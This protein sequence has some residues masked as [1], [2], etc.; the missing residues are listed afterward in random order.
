MEVVEIPLLLTVV[1]AEALSRASHRR[2]VTAGQMVRKA[3]EEFLARVS[4]IDGVRSGGEYGSFP[5]WGGS[6][7]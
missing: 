4:P 5:T 1:Q 3:I 7:K 6:V 2:G